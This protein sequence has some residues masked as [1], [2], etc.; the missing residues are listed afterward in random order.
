MIGYSKHFNTIVVG[1]G[2]M[3]SATCY[4]LSKR[5]LRVLGIEKFD[6]PHDLGSSHGYTRIIRQPYY[7]NPNYVMLIKRAYE[8]WDEIETRTNSRILYKNGSLDIGPADSWVFKGS[9]KSA[10]E[11]DLKY[12]VI[13]GKEISMRWPG[14]QLPHD[15][16]GIYQPDGGYLAPEKA[17]VSYVEAAHA[18]GAEIHGR[19][20]VLEWQPTSEGGVRVITDRAEYTADSL[21]YTAGAWNQN[22][23]PFLNGL[24]IPER[25]VLAWLQPERPEMFQPD[26][27]PVFNLLTKEGRYYGFPIHGVP[28]FKFGIYHHLEEH[29]FA[30][31]IDWEVYPDD[32]EMLREVAARYFPQGAGPT[33]TL[34]ACMFTNSPDKQFIVDLHPEYPQVS[35]A[36][37]FSGHGY[38]FASVIGEIMAD[39][40]ERQSTRHDI[41]FLSLARLTGQISDLHINKLGLPDHMVRRQNVNRQ[42]IRPGQ[43]L[44]HTTQYPRRHQPRRVGNHIRHQGRHQPH[45]RGGRRPFRQTFRTQNGRRQSPY[46]DQM[47]WDSTD[48]R[49]WDSDSVDPF[50]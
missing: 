4:E 15:L 7:E 49:Y 20:E 47:Y 2:G 9:L 24:A 12:E 8:L 3:G 43:R 11:H 26:V 44:Q 18:M 40:S 31:E 48:P 28:G 35:F 10:V 29:G 41:S 27:F 14:Y 17:I 16:M 1:V 6:I 36:A 22:L 39:L 32:E 33:L 42:I 25:Q 34:K 38:K 5:G 13:S 19:E 45:Y 23:L 50:W 46:R 37:G 21:V 30:D